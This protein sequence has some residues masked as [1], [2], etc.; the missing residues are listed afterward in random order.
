MDM[1]VASLSWRLRYNELPGACAVC[2]KSCPTR[3]NPVACS[4]PDSS[5][6]GIFQA[7]I[8]EWVAMPFSRVYSQPRNQTRVSCTAGRY[9]TT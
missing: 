3:C 9:F 5:F 4:L 7:R 2:A 8:L 1:W 6:H